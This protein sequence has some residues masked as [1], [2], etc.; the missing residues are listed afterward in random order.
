M[1]LLWNHES[2]IYYAKPD[3]GIVRK[4]DVVDVLGKE[5]IASMLAQG[6]VKAPKLAEETEEGK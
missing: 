4:G 3:L 1:R 6:F 2:P 5:E